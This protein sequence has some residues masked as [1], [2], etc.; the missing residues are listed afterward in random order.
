MRLNEDSEAYE[1]DFDDRG[2]ADVVEE[3]LRQEMLAE[4]LAKA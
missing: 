1:E 2:A 4:E 3:V